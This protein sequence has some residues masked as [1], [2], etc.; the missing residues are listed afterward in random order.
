M[1]Q[2]TYLKTLLV[3]LLLLI[4]YTKAEID[5]VGFLEVWLHAHDLRESFLSMF[6]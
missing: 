6:K 1:F 5:F 4:D 3:F 2:Y